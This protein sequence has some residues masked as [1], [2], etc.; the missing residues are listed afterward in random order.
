[1]RKSERSMTMKKKKKDRKIGNELL[2]CTS[3]PLYWKDN[4]A[5]PAWGHV[6][7]STR[8]ILVAPCRW[9]ENV[10]KVAVSSRAKLNAAVRGAQATS[11]DF[12]LIWEKVGK[13][14]GV[15]PARQSEKK[16]KAFS[17]CPY[18]QACVDA[19][20]HAR[21]ARSQVV[22]GTPPHLVCHNLH[23]VGRLW[24]D[25]PRCVIHRHHFTRFRCHVLEHCR[26]DVFAML[27]KDEAIKG[28]AACCGRQ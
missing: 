8:V 21:F 10:D 16:K 11:R 18:P 1:M 5:P 2:S 4:S 26:A 14:I 12:F 22:A 23:I 13:K 9:P 3:T 15:L 7:A 6:R 27:K 25:L 17:L 24:P 28:C 19:T 20:A